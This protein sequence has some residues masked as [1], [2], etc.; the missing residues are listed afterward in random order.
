[1]SICG[2]LALDSSNHYKSDSLI[3]M[4]SV[5]DENRSKP[6]NE[7]E[8]AH[9]QSQT[10]SVDGEK[11]LSQNQKE[12][13]DG[14]KA[15]SQNTFVS[16]PESI[17]K[18]FIYNA[19]FGTRELAPAMFS[20]IRSVYPKPWNVEVVNSMETGRDD[21]L[22]ILICPAGLAGNLSV[23]PKYYVAWQ[24]EDVQG[25]YNNPAYMETLRRALYVWDYS[26]FNMNILK[27]RDNLDTIYFPPG[28]S[29]TITTPEILSGSYLYSD[30]G[31]D[32]EVLF[33]GYCDAYPRRVQLRDNCYKAGFRMWFVSTLD[34]EG[35][36]AAIKRSKVCINMVA[37][38]P[39]VLATVRLNILLSNQACIVSEESCDKEADALYSQAGISFVTYDQI[40]TKTRELVDNPELRKRSAIKGYQWYRV[41]RNWTDIFDF[42][43]YLPNQS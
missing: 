4:E 17:N 18:I 29:S 13:V 1:M 19:S 6:V 21:I 43:H 33:L 2:S 9:S 28:F 5:N 35:M 30:E 14:E 12:L 16:Y 23:L 25:N 36:K 34:I 31:K 39:F 15:H 22:Y 10:E 40:L 20:A 24:L 41:H 38:E 3:Q 8:E 37:R 11:A 27:N 42:N 26:T 32:I 7:E